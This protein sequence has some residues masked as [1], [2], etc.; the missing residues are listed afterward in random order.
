MM[1]NRGLSTTHNPT[2]SFFTQIPTRSFSTP[3]IKFIP[4][5]EN[6]EDSDEVAVLIRGMPYRCSYGEVK[7]FF[8]GYNFLQ[9]SVEFGIHPDGRSNG[10]GVILFESEQEA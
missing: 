7:N 2:A 8:S 5:T 6:F 10:L 3:E 1:K 9:D 4:G